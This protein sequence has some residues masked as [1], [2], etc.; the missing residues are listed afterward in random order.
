MLFQ[1]ITFS[2]FILLI[3]CCSNTASARYIT[4]DP[5][6][7]DGGINTYAYVK[8]NPINWIDPKGLSKRGG[9]PPKNYN[10]HWI[11]QNVR[12]L[13][14]QIQQ[15]DPQYRYQTHR[16]GGSGCRRGW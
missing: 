5:I 7:L 3:I 11:N 4:S 8:N 13:I 2:L 9:Q 10:Q 16:T 15:Y 12:D 1:K 6:G 14:R